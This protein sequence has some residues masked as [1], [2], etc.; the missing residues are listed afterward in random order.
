M[1]PQEACLQR[2]ALLDGVPGFQSD[3]VQAQVLEARDGGQL[4]QMLCFQREVPQVKS[5]HLHHSQLVNTLTSKIKNLLLGTDSVTLVLTSSSNRVLLWGFARL[6]VY[7]ILC[8]R[9]AGIPAKQPSPF[10]KGHSAINC[11]A[12]QRHKAQHGSL[13]HWSPHTHTHTLDGQCCACQHDYSPAGSNP[14]CL[15]RE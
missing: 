5:L 13:H 7:I 15:G 6:Q 9:A 2:F 3:V 12:S 10:E 8:R 1:T 4:N 14:E 11:N